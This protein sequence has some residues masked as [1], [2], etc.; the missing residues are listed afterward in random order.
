M[1]NLT[2]W[3]TF[4]CHFI[5]HPIKHINNQF[6]IDLFFMSC[7]KYNSLKIYTTANIQFGLEGHH[8]FIKSGRK[9]KIR[10]LHIT[11]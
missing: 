11:V 7:H 1:H 6:M 9:D 3:N 4:Y 10:M 2:Y 5:R 8:S